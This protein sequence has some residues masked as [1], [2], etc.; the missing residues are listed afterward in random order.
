[1][2]DTR[3]PE[4]LTGGRT[5]LV[6]CP[7]TTDTGRDACID[8]LTAHDPSTANVL[9]ITHGESPDEWLDAWRRR[10]GEPPANHRVVTV[11]SAAG[12]RSAGERDADPVTTVGAPLPG[13]TADP[14]LSVVRTDGANTLSHLGVAV[15]D[16]LDAWREND[17]RTVACGGSVAALREW[18]DVATLFRSLHLTLHRF[19]TADAL[20]HFHLDPD[21]L[22]DV[23]RETLEQLFDRVIEEPRNRL[24]VDDRGPDADLVMEMLESRSRRIALRVVLTAPEPIAVDDLAERTVER[25]RE[26][27][28]G[29]ADPVAVKR[30]KVDLLHNHLP[31]LDAAD[32]VAFDRSNGTVRPGADVDRVLPLLE[33][34]NE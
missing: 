4:C 11:R 33:R 16:A 29:S 9:R 5:L 28:G 1:M 17:N 23:E 31:K 7:P 25:A 32:F 27:H 34:I 3:T 30:T 15:G 20:V 12:L 8:A 13:A 24:W 22:D 6:T 2:N 26:G 18:A 10:V 14:T 19:R 21:A